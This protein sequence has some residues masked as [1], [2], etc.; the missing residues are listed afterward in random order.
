MKEIS[1]ESYVSLLLEWNVQILQYFQGLNQEPRLNLKGSRHTA[2]YWP[3]K[4][5]QDATIAKIWGNHQD[6]LH[7][8]ALILKEANRDHKWVKMKC[9]KR[10]INDNTAV[11][12]KQASDNPRDVKSSLFCSIPYLLQWACGVWNWILDNA[13]NFGQCMLVR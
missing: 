11:T 13:V 9:T 4:E 12:Q 8:C 10:L 5:L 1:Y 6:T 2:L 7:T 3:S